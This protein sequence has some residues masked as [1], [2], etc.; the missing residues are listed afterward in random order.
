MLNREYPRETS[1]NIKQTLAKGGAARRS[2]GEWLQQNTMTE[3][4]ASVHV[5]FAVTHCNRK[6]DV[7]TNFT[8]SAFLEYFHDGSKFSINSVNS[9]GTEQRGAYTQY[10]YSEALRDLPTRRRN[11]YHACVWIARD[12]GRFAAWEFQCD[13]A[14][15]VRSSR[16]GSISLHVIFATPLYL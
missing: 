16:N 4:R 7:R 10:G 2:L 3:T 9:A 13:Q 14:L 8:I 5:S 11:S 1:G 15:A 12:G 6:G